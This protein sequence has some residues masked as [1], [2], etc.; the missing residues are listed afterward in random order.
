VNANT[1]LYKYHTKLISNTRFHK[2]DTVRVKGWYGLTISCIG[3]KL[4]ARGAAIPQTDEDPIQIQYRKPEG[5]TG[6]VEKTF[7]STTI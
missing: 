2:G 3:L 6:V 7:Q 4:T 5:S 1:G